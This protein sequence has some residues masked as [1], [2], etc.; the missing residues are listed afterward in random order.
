M[1]IKRCVAAF[2]ASAD[3]TPRMYTVGLLV[4]ASDPIIKGR[5]HLFEDVET[6]VA[7]KAARQA[8][9]VEQATA[10]PGEKRS[11]A[12]RQQAKKAAPSKPEPKAAAKSDDGGAK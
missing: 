11:V 10:E 6:H 8:P 3:G 12:P 5:E 4:D 1:A 7:D 9:K 2:A